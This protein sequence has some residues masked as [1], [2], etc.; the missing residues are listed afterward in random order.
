MIEAGDGE[1]GLEAAD[2]AAESI[3]LLVTD[4]VMPRMGGVEL[5]TKL[6]ASRPELRVLFLS[7]HAAPESAEGARALRHARFLQKPFGDEALLR[8]IRLLLGED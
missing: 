6:Q 4:L 7:G 3:D 1:A 2:Q 5:A 8:E